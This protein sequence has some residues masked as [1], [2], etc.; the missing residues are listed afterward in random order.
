[1]RYVV[2]RRPGYWVARREDDEVGIYGEFRQILEYIDHGELED[3]IVHEI[4]RRLVQNRDNI[5]DML[6]DATT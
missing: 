5:V 2:E 3:L 1:M 4:T 6:I